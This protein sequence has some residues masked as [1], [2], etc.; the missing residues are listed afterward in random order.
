MVRKVRVLLVVAVAAV[1]NVGATVG[2]ARAASAESATN[3]AAYATPSGMMVARSAFATS[4]RRGGGGVEQATAAD[5]CPLTVYGYTG[6]LLCGSRYWECDW[7]GGTYQPEVFAISPT[8]RIWHIHSTSGGWQEMPNNGRADSVHTC[9]RNGD[10][11][12]Q[13]EVEVFANDVDGYDV[14]YSYYSNYPTPRWLGWYY[15]PGT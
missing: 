9:Y 3:E 14:W 15:Y 7:D 1:L 6:Y 5:G 12:R 10:G 13:V 4:A 2:P 8:R 11:Q